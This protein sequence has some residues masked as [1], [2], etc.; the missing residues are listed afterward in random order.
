MHVV[1]VIINFF[2]SDFV[3]LFNRMIFFLSYLLSLF[4]VMHNRRKF[5]SV[6]NVLC[7][8]KFVYVDGVFFVLPCPIEFAACCVTF[9]VLILAYI[10]FY[11][12][13]ELVPRV[14][15]GIWDRVFPCVYRSC[16]SCSY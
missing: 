14:H 2:N 4:P 13:S 11:V 1:L 15:F 16:V 3:G 9:L 12:P 6:L 5:N 10:S 7:F 8:A